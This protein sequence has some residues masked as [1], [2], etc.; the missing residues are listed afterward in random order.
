MEAAFY[1][2]PIF[3]SCCRKPRKH[4]SLSQKIAYFSTK[5]CKP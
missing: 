3:W 2:E 5:H 4:K 1:F